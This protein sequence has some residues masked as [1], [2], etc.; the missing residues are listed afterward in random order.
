M[1][2]SALIVALAVGLA[3]PVALAGPAER[4]GRIDKRLSHAEANGAWAPG[5]RGDRI[6]SRIDLFEDRVDRRENVRDRAVTLGPRDLIEDRYDR[7]EDV[8]DRAENRIDRRRR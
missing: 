4:L 6:E 2:K 3:A 5:S 1:L 7:A 8:R